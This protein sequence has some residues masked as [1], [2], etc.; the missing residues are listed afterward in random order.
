MEYPLI[1]DSMNLLEYYK[2]ANNVDALVS[3]IIYVESSFTE[4]PKA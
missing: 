4:V 3:I 2:A 1:Y